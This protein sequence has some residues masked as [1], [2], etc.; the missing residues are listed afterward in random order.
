MHGRG[1]AAD[2]PSDE[3]A[4][5]RGSLPEHSERERRVQRRIHEREHELQQVHDVIKRVRHVRGELVVFGDFDDGREA[6]WFIT[7]SDA[8][9]VYACQQAQRL[10]AS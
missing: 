1:Q 7:G 2:E 4:V 6:A 10:V 9:S 3:C 8:T 5:T